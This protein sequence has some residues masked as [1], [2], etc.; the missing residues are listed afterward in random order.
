MTTVTPEPGLFDSTTEP[1]PGWTPPKARRAGRPKGSANKP[2]DKPP[3]PVT[4]HRTPNTEEIGKVMGEI[5]SLP[6]IMFSLPQFPTLQCDYCQSHFLVQG[7]KTG[8]QLAVLSEDHPAF[9]A[10]LQNITLAWGGLSMFGVI[11]EY[12]AKP[13]VH[14]G[15]EA[16][17]PAA[18]MLGVPAR[19]P[20]EPREHVHSAASEGTA[21]PRRRRGTPTP[22][23]TPIPDTE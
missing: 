17:A 15:P 20:K 10:A 8:E 16:L 9:R 22:A 6:A 5:L 23:P 1:A 11:G 13:L 7:P 3:V 4:P 12:I 2:K 21:R 18:P 14:H 19:K